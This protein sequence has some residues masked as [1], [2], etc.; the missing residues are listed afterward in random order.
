MEARP[1]LQRIPLSLQL[2]QRHTGSYRLPLSLSLPFTRSQWRTPPRLGGHRWRRAA[3]PQHGLF[4]DGRVRAVVHVLEAAAASYTWERPSHPKPAWH[5]RTRS[6]ARAGDLCFWRKYLVV[7]FESRIFVYLFI[8]MIWRGGTEYYH[9]IGI[10]INKFNLLQRRIS[11]YLADQQHLHLSMLMA[12]Q[13]SW[14][15]P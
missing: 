1:S 11:M 4:G 15:R 13:H 8:I 9:G 6:R 5:T 2:R 12:L 7:L 14:V 10:Q 3:L